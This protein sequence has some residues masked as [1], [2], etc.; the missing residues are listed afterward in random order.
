MLGS[1]TGP[2]AG[3]TGLEATPYGALTTLPAF[4]QRVHTYTRRGVP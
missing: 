4:R 1:E 2:D 3:L